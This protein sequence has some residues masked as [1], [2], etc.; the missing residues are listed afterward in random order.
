MLRLGALTVA[1][2]EMAELFGVVN[3]LGV[4]IR[5]FVVP[6]AMA[7]KLAEEELVSPLKLAWLVIVP[8]V[9]SELVTTTFTERPVRR[10]WKDWKL[11]LLG[12]NCATKSVSVAS[13]ENEVVLKFPVPHTI[14]DGVR[15]ITDTPSV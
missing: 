15:L 8:T 5:R 2:M 6:A 9:V 7:W 12:F 4:E 10:F 13:G 11:R 1:A 3:P 14:P